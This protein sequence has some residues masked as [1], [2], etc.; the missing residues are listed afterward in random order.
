[1]AWLTGWQV[2]V[3]CMQICNGKAVVTVRCNT[4]SSLWGSMA[5]RARKKTKIGSRTR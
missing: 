2:Y 5:N 4:E 3:A 1:M